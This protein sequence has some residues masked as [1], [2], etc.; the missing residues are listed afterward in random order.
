V[1]FGMVSLNDYYT[2]MPKN[3]LADREDFIVYSAELMKNRLIGS[4]IADAMGWNQEEV[5]QHVLS[6]QAGQLF[7]KMIFMR[8]VPNLKRLGLLTPKVRKAFTD[9]EIIQFESY[10]VEADDRSL[11]L[12]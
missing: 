10:D 8:V 11:G 12:A 4:Q 6:S 2:D 9:L 7:R 5:A 1:A 3:E